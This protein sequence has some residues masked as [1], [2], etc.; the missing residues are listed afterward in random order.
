MEE[1]DEERGQHMQRYDDDN[2][3]LDDVEDDC[4]KKKKKLFTI[5]I[6]INTKFS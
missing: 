4:N 6:K 3:L 2:E 1:F 5:F